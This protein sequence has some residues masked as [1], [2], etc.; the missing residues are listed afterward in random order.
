MK[1][2]VVDTNIL[3]YWY[4]TG[5]IASNSN[6][7]SIVPIFSIITQIEALGFKGISDKENKAIMNIFNTGE[8]IYVDQDIADKSVSLRQNIKIKTPDAIIAATALIEDAELWTANTSDFSNVKG[9]KLRNP[10]K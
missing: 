10:L 8:I 9:L 7:N 2:V 1:R 4:K 5:V 3:I 6:L